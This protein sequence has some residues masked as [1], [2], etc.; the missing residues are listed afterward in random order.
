M[1]AYF[2]IITK[3][4]QLISLFYNRSLY[5]RILNYV[6]EVSCHEVSIVTCKSSPTDVSL[7]NRVYDGWS[8]MYGLWWRGKLT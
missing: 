2:V 3:Y 1:L 7:R 8:M 6:L 4:D 5:F